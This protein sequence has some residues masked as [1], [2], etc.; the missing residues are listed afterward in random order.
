MCVPRRNKKLLE[1]GAYLLGAVNIIINLYLAVSWLV[2]HVLMRHCSSAPAFF[3]IIRFTKDTVE[4]LEPVEGTDKY[5]RFFSFYIYEKTLEFHDHQIKLLGGM[6]LTVNLITACAAALG[7]LGVYK[8]MPVLVR[9]WAY[10]LALYIGWW[11]SWVSNHHLK[12][13][14][15]NVTDMADISV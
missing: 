2:L 4:V 14:L 15:Q 3:R 8:K 12:T 6:G 7:M 13:E 5:R 9:I 1:A 10:S 11:A